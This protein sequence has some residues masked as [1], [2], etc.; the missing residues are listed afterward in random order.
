MGFIQKYIN[1]YLHKINTQTA[2]WQRYTNS[3]LFLG[4]SGKVVHN[5]LA[6][7]MNVVFI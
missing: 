7:A 6:Y 4:V 5:L 3:R 2:L 1:P